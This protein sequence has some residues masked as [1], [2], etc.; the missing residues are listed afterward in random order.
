MWQKVSCSGI[1][2][3]LSKCILCHFAY[4]TGLDVAHRSISARVWVFIIWGLFQK[5]RDWINVWCPDVFTVYCIASVI[6]GHQHV[7][8]E[9]FTAVV[10]KSIIFWDMTPCSPFSVN[11]RFGGT[12]RLH[13]RVEISLKLASCKENCKLFFYLAVH[14]VYIWE[15][16]RI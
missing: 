2:H 1:T 16:L 4:L 10:M 14:E 11:H 7:G 6:H 12:Y 8:F 3:N 9:V 15:C 5:Y 13:L